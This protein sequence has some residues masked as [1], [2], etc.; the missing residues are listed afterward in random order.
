[1]RE[2]RSLCQGVA[3]WLMEREVKARAAWPGQEREGLEAPVV[4]VSLRSCQ[5]LSGGFQDYLGEVY[6]EQTGA[7]EEFYGKKL[8]LELGLDVYAPE[9]AA[10]RE[11]QQLAQQ[12]IQTLTLGAPEGLQVG[13]MTCGEIRWDEQQCCLVREMTAH[14]T[15]WLRAVA[16][17]SGEFI[18]FELRGGWKI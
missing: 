17:Q 2:T 8:E 15:A 5:A 13:E 4:F 3:A 16:A 11:L 9:T 18:D 14:C 10:E 12:V 1:M 6:N 7:W